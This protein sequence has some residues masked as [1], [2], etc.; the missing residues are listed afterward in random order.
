MGNSEGKLLFGMEIEFGFSAIDDRGNPVDSGNALGLYLT[1]CSE[2]FVHLQGRG[3]FCMYLTN[4][5]LVYPDL[6]HP[7]LATAESSSPVALCNS[8]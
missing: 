6:G 8:R 4:G 1:V 5:S 2:K 7:E 3:E